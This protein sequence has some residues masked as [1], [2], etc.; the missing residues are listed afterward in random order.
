MI[1]GHVNK[2]SPLVLLVVPWLL[3]FCLY[4]LG[5]TSNLIDIPRSLIGF[6]A[7]VFFS[8]CVSQ[9]ICNKLK[10][11]TYY[12]V[13]DNK[14]NNFLIKIAF[15]WLS[16]SLLEIFFSGGLP[17]LWSMT[18]S[19]KD[20]TNFGIKSVHGI[21]NALYFTLI[22]GTTYSYF[23]NKTSKK[24]FYITCLLIWPVLMLGRG[25]LLTALVQIV[26][27]YVYFNGLSKVQIFK[28]LCTALVSILAFGAIGDMRG[29]ENP[30]AYLIL[31]PYKEL[32]EKIPSG[33]IWVYI[34]ITSPLA[35]YANNAGVL[36]PTWSFNYSAVNLFPS[37]LR[38]AGLDRAD[39]FEFVDPMLNV[40]TIFASSHSDFSYF[41]D[42]ILVT[43]LILWAF[44]WYAKLLKSSV[45]ILPYSM[46]GCVLFFSIF[47][48]L[49]LLYPYLFSTLL[50]GFVA[51]RCTTPRLSTT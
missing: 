42:A 51:M 47:Y 11:R 37:L 10:T 43:M 48:N 31:D 9:L 7:L 17:I 25:I 22:G 35:N 4:A 34:Y 12:A 29:D 24:I 44:F 5:L 26:L 19:S 49:F 8:V 1:R 15:I 2:I 16:G 3:V 38:P 36:D 32:F 33:F 40:S 18:G 23:K 6:F 27:C 28:I 46:V 50:Q 41:G 13:D 39:D 21:M 45:Y 14:L 20:Y 30:L